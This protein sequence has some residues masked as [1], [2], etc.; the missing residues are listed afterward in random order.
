L[1]PVAVRV[2]EYGTPTEPL[3][4]EVPEGEVICNAGYTVRVI[5]LLAA[6]TTPVESETVKVR[7]V[8]VTETVGVPLKT[9]VVEKVIPTGSVPLA[10]FHE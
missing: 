5:D 10:R 9:P 1:P 7:L 8:A 6:A 3:G 4:N 2:V